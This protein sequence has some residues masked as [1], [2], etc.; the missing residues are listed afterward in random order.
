MIRLHGISK[1]FPSPA[2]PRQVLKNVDLQVGKG[3]IVSIVGANGT[4]KTTLLRL[5]A[6]LLDPD[7]GQVD[8]GAPNGGRVHVALVPQRYRES[9]FPWRTVWG[10]VEL[11]FETRARPAEDFVPG[12][13]IGAMLDTLG[14]RHLRAAR[15]GTLSGGQAQLVAIAR[16]LAA[17]WNTVLLL[18]EPFS[19]LD[20]TNLARASD[21]VVRT[22][23][24]RGAAT[25][26]ITHDLDIGILIANRIAVLGNGSSGLAAVID[27]PAGGRL[28]IGQLTKPAFVECKR[29]TLQAI[30]S[31]S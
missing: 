31:P 4:G 29:K 6:G 7:A 18:D 8:L 14:I 24:E 28:D 9:L 15:P 26:V 25:L 20:G 16:G 11:P 23:R 1:S 21:L 30:L 3:E 2:G 13:A 27:S 5:V 10:N 19:A 17:P 12:N 22:T